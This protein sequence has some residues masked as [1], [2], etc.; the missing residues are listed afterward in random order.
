[1]IR[2]QQHKNGKGKEGRKIKKSSQPEQMQVNY[3]GAS[4]GRDRQKN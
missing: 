1:M 2:T 3:V 4:G